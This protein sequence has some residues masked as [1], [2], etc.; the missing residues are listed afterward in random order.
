MTTR[1]RKESQVK[2]AKKCRQ[3]IQ[4]QQDS[5]REEQVKEGKQYRQILPTAEVTMERENDRRSIVNDNA[6]KKAG[7]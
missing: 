5:E 6:N 3:S 4:T 1:L 7:A 2:Q